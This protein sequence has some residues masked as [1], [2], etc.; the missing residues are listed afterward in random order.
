MTISEWKVSGVYGTKTT[1]V[2]TKQQENKLTVVY[3]AEARSRTTGSAKIS[4][5]IPTVMAME[6]EALMPQTRRKK[7]K[8]GQF[9]A[10]AQATVKMVKRAKLE[11]MM[12]RRPY[13]SLRG[14]SR[15]GPGM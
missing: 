5:M 15:R 1:F 6:L 11:T 12:T 3:M 9:G 8:E 7:R 13:A 10:R 2:R 4:P 14:E